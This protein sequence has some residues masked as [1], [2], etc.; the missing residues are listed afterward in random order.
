[1]RLEDWREQQKLSVA[2]LGRLIGT[3]GVSAGRYCRGRVPDPKIV[4]AIYRATGGQVMPNDL[5][6]LPVLNAA[7]RCAPLPP[8]AL[9][10][11]GVERC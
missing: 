4:I 9:V 1:M 6:D 8:D 10:A 7:G 11:S 2:Q 3:A 5:Y